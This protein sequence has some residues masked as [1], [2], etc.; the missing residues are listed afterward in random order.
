MS[1]STIWD[2]IPQQLD[3]GCPISGNRY[4]AVGASIVAMTSSATLFG[5]Q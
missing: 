3:G 2:T 4:R 1:R 5:P